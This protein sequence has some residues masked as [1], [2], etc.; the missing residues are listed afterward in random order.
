MGRVPEKF[1]LE[2]EF[3]RARVFGVWRLATGNVIFL[4]KLSVLREKIVWFI[5]DLL[6]LYNNIFEKKFLK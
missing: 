4:A 2:N 1:F 3:I 5:I 6:L